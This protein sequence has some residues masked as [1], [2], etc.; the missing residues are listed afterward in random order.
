MTL[1]V[2]CVFDL[3]IFVSGYL[4][5]PV[6]S[7]WGKAV[8]MYSNNYFSVYPKTTQQPSVRYSHLE[9]ENKKL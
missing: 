2:W 7:L 1:Q 6:G 4:R 8:V 3:Q 5:W 9:F